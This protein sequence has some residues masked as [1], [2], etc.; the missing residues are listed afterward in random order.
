MPLKNQPTSP[1]KSLSLLAVLFL[2]IGVGGTYQFLS[3]LLLQAQQQVVVAEA[4]LKGL[5]DD[6]SQL[7][8]ARQQIEVAKLEMTAAYSG[9]NFSNLPLIYPQHEDVP[10]LYLQLEALTVEGQRAGLTNVTYQVGQPQLDATTNTV[11]IPVNVSGSG[12]YLVT[13]DFISKL[14]RNLRLL[15]IQSLNLAQALDKVT[16]APTGEF[17]FNAAAVARAK[18][19]SPAF[20]VPTNQS[21]Q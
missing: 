12:S 4:E 2:L 13:K 5:V 15:S 20:A 17:T 8:R 11:T 16:G 7:N 14:E 21:A 10:G 1:N 18:S 3:P 19:L 9:L 6:A